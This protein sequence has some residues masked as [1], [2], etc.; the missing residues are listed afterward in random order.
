M[1][2]DKRKLGIILIIVTVI[3]TYAY[4][5]YSKNKNKVNNSITQNKVDDENDG[6]SKEKSS[7][8]IVNPTQ[9]D[10]DK[11]TK[12][13]F[14]SKYPFKWGL[15]I[16]QSYRYSYISSLQFNPAISST[17]KS[18]ELQKINLSI[19]AILNFK[20]L[21]Q[22][23]NRIHVGFQLSQPQITQGAVSIPEMEFLYGQFFIVTF[24]P[25]GEIIDSHFPKGLDN[26]EK[27][28][29][30]ELVSSL[31]VVF[32][33]EK[34]QIASN[35][36]AEEKD[37]T[38]RYSSNYSIKGHHILKKKTGYTHIEN[39]K[40]SAN[41]KLTALI[42]FSEF[43]SVLSEEKGWFK[44]ASAK[45]EISLKNDD[46][47]FI[48]IKKEITLEKTALDNSDLLLWKFNTLREGLD[49]LQKSQLGKK[50]NTWDSIEKKKIK[51]HLKNKKLSYFI[52]DLN[53]IYAKKGVSISEKMIYLSKLNAYLIAY[54][55]DIELVIQM[56][57]DK[58]INTDISRSII[59]YLADMK[60]KEAQ[61]GLAMFIQKEQDNI[62]LL[63]QAIISSGTIEKPTEVLANALWENVATEAET[64]GTALL[65]LGSNSYFSDKSGNDELAISIK[66][67]LLSNLGTVDGLMASYNL[68]AIANS[69]GEKASEKKMVF[70]S[71][72]HYVSHDDA[73][74]RQSVYK[75][76]GKLDDDQSRQLL[77]SALRDET[78]SDVKKDVIDSLSERKDKAT[79]D[80]IETVGSSLETEKDKR[81]YKKMIDLLGESLEENKKAVKI[82]E[83]QLLEPLPKDLKKRIYEALY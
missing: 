65:A 4:F 78:S 22:S 45:D 3:S 62:P 66:Q 6:P 11:H 16:K 38:G 31:Q 43:N 55:E 7:N 79:D 56:I 26:N 76:F 51:A 5:H 46:A 8:T 20:V 23:I 83:Q 15:G 48:H 24:D 21:S 69:V 19:N 53:A 10:K 74:I 82:L 60:I 39:Q 50:N 29:L 54:P 28:P 35:W 57:L 1:S 77:L 34:N 41:K 40:I 14:F 12:K 64:S 72:R 68:R 18:S 70:D 75:V 2:L 73:H 17:T 63:E 61:Q 52:N 47:V 81:I 49:S 27:I 33:E 71:V 58:K 59:S 9:V 42:H 30:L 13:L 37:S 44:K 67:R 80:V 25:K 36:S 32:P